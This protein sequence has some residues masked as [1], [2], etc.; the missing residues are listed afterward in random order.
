MKNKKI[1]EED[2]LKGKKLAVYKR[3]S[4][5]DQDLEKRQ[6]QVIDNYLNRHGLNLSE[7]ESFPETG[8]AYSNKQRPV[9]QKLLKMA[10]REEIDGIIV[11][12]GDRLSRQTKEHFELREFFD[13]I[14]LPVMIASKGELYKKSETQELIKH[15]IEDGLSKLESDNNSI[16]TKDTLENLRLKGRFTGGVIPYGYTSVKEKAN[17]VDP[18]AKR[19]KDLNK[20]VGIQP[21]QEQI[22]VI[23]NIFKSYQGG[24]TFSSIAKD[25]NTQRPSESWTYKKVRYIISNP[26]YTGHFVH[27]RKS[28]SHS[29]TPIE[30]WVWIPCSWFKDP[31]PIPKEQW[32]ACWKKYQD[33]K[34][35]NRY[36]L[37]TSFSFQGVISCS[38][39]K[40]MRGIN[41]KT[42]SKKDPDESHGY[43]Y[44]K[45][46][47]GQ[48]VDADK[49]N[50]LF[51]SFYRSQPLPLDKVI[52]ELYH[53]F[54]EEYEQKAKRVLEWESILEKEEEFLQRLLKVKGAD[55]VAN[56]YLNE[57]TEVKDLAYLIAKKK[58]EESISYLKKSIKGE[59]S[60]MTELYEML[61]DSNRFFT[62]FQKSLKDI[63]EAP[64]YLRT[65]VLC[66]VKE[67]SYHE[68]KI[69]LTFYLMPP[70]S[71]SIN[72]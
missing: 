72:P 13:Q 65:L 54:T 14:G 49:L 24:A 19:P 67:C 47:C 35:K 8:S 15:L 41:Q 6:N 16:R 28:G 40:M 17:E 1:T 51:R 27:H 68:G 52:K 46:T 64:H 36:Y 38:C 45:C 10:E 26:F 71:I 57:T 9:F 29:F 21:N 7:L 25:L 4:T 11:S 50:E 58:A 5:E 63:E 12:D 31:P 60:F 48:K 44:Y 23:K 3:V 61:E 30:E 22:E 55:K 43:R 34:G 66:M 69:L 42:K 2:F 20:V 53:R 37:H 62:L 56:V 39:G 70:Q 18:E 32:L 59:Q 33:T